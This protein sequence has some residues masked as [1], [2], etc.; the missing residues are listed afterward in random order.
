MYDP[1]P[2]LPHN[3]QRFIRSLKTLRIP[4]G[5]TAFTIGLLATLWFLIRVIPKPSRAAYPC[6]QATA[7][8]MAGFVV[9]LSSLVGSVW[10]FGRFRRA[11]A[12]RTSLVAILF[13]T[14]RGFVIFR[15]T[16]SISSYFLCKTSIIYHRVFST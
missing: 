1:I 13:F 16:L 4:N 14:G 11:A 6:M 12:G 2:H 8:F 15:F 10:A 9:Y 7:P 3:F 5:L